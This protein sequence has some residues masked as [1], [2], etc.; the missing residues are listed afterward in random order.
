MAI[1][2]LQFLCSL[3]IALSTKTDLSNNYQGHIQRNI[4]AKIIIIIT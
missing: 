1:K 3:S 2:A 4:V